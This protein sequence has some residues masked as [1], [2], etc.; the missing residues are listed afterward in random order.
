MAST[1]AGKGRLA[2]STNA[3][4]SSRP[5]K[6]SPTHGRLNAS[7]CSCANTNR[8]T[9]HCPRP[10]SPKP[11]NTVRAIHNPR[12]L[13]SQMAYLVSSAATAFSTNYFMT[14]CRRATLRTSALNCFLQ[15]LVFARQH[16]LSQPP[17]QHDRADDPR[18]GQLQRQGAR[19]AYFE[20]T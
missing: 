10:N 9:R 16:A 14:H 20:I 2:S 19:R 15:P 12:G 7:N 18:H 11:A 6:L 5:N 1:C 13:N 4:S 3:S 8:C 17:T